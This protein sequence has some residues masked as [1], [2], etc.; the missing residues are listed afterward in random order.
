MAPVPRPSLLRQGGSAGG[1]RGGPPRWEP[2][3]ASSSWAPPGRPGIQ[4]WES[5]RQVPA[6]HPRL[7]GQ[8]AQAELFHQGSQPYMQETL[9]GARQRVKA[10]QGRGRNSQALKAGT[11]SDS[12]PVLLPP[13]PPQLSANPALHPGAGSL[14]AL[15]PPGRKGRE[16]RPASPPPQ[17]PHPREG[18]CQIPCLSGGSRRVGGGVI[19]PQECGVRRAFPAITRRGRGWRANG[20]NYHSD[21]NAGQLTPSQLVP[22]TPTL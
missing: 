15:P 22:G 5:R 19:Q 9:K 4:I 2:T 6:M 11:P 14:L 7:S 21:R 1:Q 20:F 13:S 12:A 8:Q 18:K 3:E 16:A 10:L 17:L